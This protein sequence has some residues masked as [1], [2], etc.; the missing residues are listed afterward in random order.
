[1]KTGESSTVKIYPT[2]KKCFKKILK[3]FRISLSLNMRL[4]SMDSDHRKNLQST[5]N[6][7]HKTKSSMIGSLLKIVI[8]SK[9]TGGDYHD[10]IFRHHKDFQKK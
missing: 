10:N 6:Q 5:K 7:S 8:S 1:M 3:Y 9:N 4:L 2:T